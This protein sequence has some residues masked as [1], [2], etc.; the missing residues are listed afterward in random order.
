[1]TRHKI[2]G[3][4]ERLNASGSLL[5]DGRH[6]LNLATIIIGHTS[7][8]WVA[9]EGPALGNMFLDTDAN[10][11]SRYDVYSYNR[12]LVITR[13]DGIIAFVA[14][15]DEYNK[16]EEFSNIFSDQRALSTFLRVLSALGTYL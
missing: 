5:A 15:L 4:R 1:M 3:L 8:A 11:Q 14:G 12:G 6:W 2:A 10:A 9:F 16:V 7:S 13:P